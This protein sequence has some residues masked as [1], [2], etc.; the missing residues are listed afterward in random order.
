[1]EV[2]VIVSQSEYT[3]MVCFMVIHFISSCVP[4]P[5]DSVHYHSIGICQHHLTTVPIRAQYWSVSI[6][7][8]YTDNIDTSKVLSFS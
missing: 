3:V 5:T 4:S 6:T 1:M 2:D 7:P 8:Q